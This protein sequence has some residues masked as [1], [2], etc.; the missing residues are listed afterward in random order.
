M[1]RQF[2]RFCN[3]RNTTELLASSARADDADA[4]ESAR[5]FTR[6]NIPIQDSEGG[7]VSPN[8]LEIE[9]REIAQL[10]FPNR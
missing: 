2:A 7:F 4:R 6:G 1:F 8:D 9:R 3:R 5:R 10:T